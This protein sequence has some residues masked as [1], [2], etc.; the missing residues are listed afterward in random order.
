[1]PGEVLDGVVKDV[2]RSGGNET[3]DWE[4][5][6]DI[7]G[8]SCTIRRFTVRVLGCLHYIVQYDNLDSLPRGYEDLTP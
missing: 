5:G 3:V 7:R 6:I 2:Y 4:K 8:T 1:M